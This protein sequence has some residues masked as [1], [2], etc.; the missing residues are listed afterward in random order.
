VGGKNKE[1]VV[2]VQLIRRIIGILAG[3][4]SPAEISAVQIRQ[5]SARAR[6][7]SKSPIC[8]ALGIV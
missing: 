8:A 7:G 2:E 6:Q 1:E 5:P 3:A 4:S